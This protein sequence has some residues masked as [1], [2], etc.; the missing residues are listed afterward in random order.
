M[1]KYYSKTTVYLTQRQK[2]LMTKLMPYK[3]SGLLRD[4]LDIVLIKDNNWITPEEYKNDPELLGLIYEYRR[5][6][7]QSQET[8]KNREALKA[9]LW[10]FFD[11]ESIPY[12]CAKAGHRTALKICRK[13]I[14]EF[15]AKGYVISDRLAEDMIVEYVH[16]IEALGKDDEAWAQWEALEAAN[17]RREAAEEAA[18]EASNILGNN[19]KEY[20]S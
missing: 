18:K 17:R 13:L 20:L 10:K 14:T 15:R 9:E 4:I 5:F 12:N 6:L 19:G 1:E 11:S 8:F 3:L 16:T 7:N 2:D